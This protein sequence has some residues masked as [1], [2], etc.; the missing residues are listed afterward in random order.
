MH[1]IFGTLIFSQNFMSV[2]IDMFFSVGESIGH[3]STMFFY[4]IHKSHVCRISVWFSNSQWPSWL[5]W[6]VAHFPFLLVISHQFCWVLSFLYG[7]PPQPW[8]NF[9]ISFTLVFNLFHVIHIL[10]LWGFNVFIK[11][12]IWLTFP[13]HNLSLKKVR[14]GIH[15]ATWD[16]ACSPWF[17]LLTFLQ[18]LKQIK[19]NMLILKE[20]P[21]SRFL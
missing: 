8:T 6:L 12:F 9:H 14:T 10:F 7:F 1:F 20:H 5:S 3:D 11:G 21:W 19:L 4:F 18:W 16:M 13:Q 17:T 15:A 2:L